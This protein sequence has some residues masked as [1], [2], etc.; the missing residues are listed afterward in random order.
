M[1]QGSL[2]VI[3]GP[4]GAGK[5]TLVKRILERVPNTWV[6][7]SA[8]TR[9]PR[10]GEVD[11]IDYQFMTADEFE[12]D[13]EAGGFVEWASVHSHYYGTP[14]APIEEQLAAGKTVLL[15]IDV[16]GG[17]QVQDKLPQAK[18]VFIAPPNMEVL[19]Q[20]LRSRGTDSEEAIVQRMH[21][22]VGEMEASAR[23]DAVI[24]NDDLDRAT[25]EL[26]KMIQS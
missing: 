8:T 2:F 19:E 6:S 4:S 15:E 13:I 1:P 10:A 24:V 26:V 17:F 20:R 3:S 12:R 25:E 14:V 7:I 22:A 5:G 9:E 21:N 23:Y 11:G 16:Q 18:L